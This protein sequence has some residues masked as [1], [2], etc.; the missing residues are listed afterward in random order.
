[1][2]FKQQTICRFRK[3]AFLLLSTEIAYTPTQ[4]QRMGPNTPKPVD[5][6]VEKIVKEATNNSEL[7]TLA[8]ELLDVVGPRL[9]GTPQ[10]T[11]A[12]EWALK[13]FQRWGISAKNQQF[14]EW[15][16]WER[17]ISHIRSEERRVGKEW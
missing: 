3:L 17:G 12:N 4:A 6:I 7:E 13:T 15:H 16:G 5:P 11:N 14:G 9:V 2:K 8:F 1:M 10:M